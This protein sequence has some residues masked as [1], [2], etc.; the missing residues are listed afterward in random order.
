MSRRAILTVV[1]VAATLVCTTVAAPSRNTAAARATPC[2]SAIQNVTSLIPSC[3]WVPDLSDA[4]ITETEFTNIVMG[5]CSNAGY[6]YQGLRCSHTLVADALEEAAALCQ[7]EELYSLLDD[8]IAA[9]LT[10]MYMVCGRNENTLCFAKYSEY[11]KHFD[12]NIVPPEE[13]LNAFCEGCSV[14]LWNDGLRFPDPSLSD[15]I[16]ISMGACMREKGALGRYCS[17]VFDEARTYMQS[18]N[19]AEFYRLGCESPC[20]HRALTLYRTI[21]PTLPEMPYVLCNRNTS[22][23]DGSLCWEVVVKALVETQLLEMCMV[24]SP[25]PSCAV[26]IQSFIAK[27]GCCGR[28][29]LPIVSSVMPEMYPSLVMM[30]DM[31]GVKEDCPSDPV[32]DRQIKLELMIQNLDMQKINADYTRMIT[33]LAVL[34][35]VRESGVGIVIKNIRRH[36]TTLYVNFTCD[37]TPHKNLVKQQF[38]ANLYAGRFVLPFSNMNLSLRV[39]PY[40]PLTIIVPEMPASS[41]VS[42]PA[43][44]SAEFNSDNTDAAAT[45]AVGFSAIVAALVAAF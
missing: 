11:S 19:F 39:D 36:S 21:I 13:A 9:V 29:I 17:R 16:S 41:S 4:N 37:S 15:M 43:S 45:I 8:S 44:Q 6:E 5:L 31:Q 10:S 3:S 7:R 33:D 40:I 24:S 38:E 18:F 22:T 12:N 28:L 2:E 1:V 23:P 27:A 34:S 42:L 14:N 25:A 26:I 32:P 20:Y 35:G 30:F